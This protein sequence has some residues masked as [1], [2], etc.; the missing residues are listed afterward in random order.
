M[1]KTDQS[2]HKICIAAIRRHTNR[3]NIHEFLYTSF[4]PEP[5]HFTQ[6]IASKLDFTLHNEELCICST[7][8]D[9]QNWS[10]LT[11]QRIITYIDGKQQEGNMKEAIG[12]DF[13]MFKDRKVKTNFG[14]VIF[15]EGKEIQFFIETTKASMIMIYGVKTLNQI[16][17]NN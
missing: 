2:L 12:N 4:Y 15:P 13:G 6:E 3:E 1:N 11:T 7:I 5:S 17:P 9:D 14:K 10:V 8:V 16:S